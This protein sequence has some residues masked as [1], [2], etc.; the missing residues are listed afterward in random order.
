MATFNFPDSSAI[1]LQ[2]FEKIKGIRKINWNSMAGDNN[3]LR[4]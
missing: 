1:Q 4:L 2:H 3:N